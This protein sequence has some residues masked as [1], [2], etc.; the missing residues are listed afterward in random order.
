MR[1]VYSQPVRLTRCLGAAV[2]R[3]SVT[4]AFAI[5]VPCVLRRLPECGIFRAC[6]VIWYLWITR[7]SYHDRVDS[8]ELQHL[9]LD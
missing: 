9:E 2:L 1:R 5:A 7:D 8:S 3:W 4:M 6:Q